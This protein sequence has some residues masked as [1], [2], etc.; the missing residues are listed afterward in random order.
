MVGNSTPFTSCLRATKYIPAD[1]A[2]AI[3]DNRIHIS[4]VLPHGTRAQT[5]PAATLVK[6]NWR[7][8]SAALFC[9][10]NHAVT[11]ANQIKIDSHIL[12]V[13]NFTVPLHFWTSCYSCLTTHSTENSAV[14]EAPLSKGPLAHIRLLLC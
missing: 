4:D 7:T 3:T 8:L 2:N 13:S 1:A 11:A 9:Q 10:A 5:A 6:M 14:F 12:D